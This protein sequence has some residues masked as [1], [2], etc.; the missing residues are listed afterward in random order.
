M[1][2]DSAGVVLSSPASA[3]GGKLMARA[4]AERSASR[5]DSETIGSLVEVY[6]RD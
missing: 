5:S 4:D 3:I 6:R 2:S 1:P